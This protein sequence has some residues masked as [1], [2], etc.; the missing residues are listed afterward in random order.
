MRT[1]PEAG[2]M[3]PWGH[4]AFGYLLYSVLVRVR[5]RRPPGDA[6]TV[7]LAVGTQF[8]DLVDK[9]LA[10]SLDV[11]PS[12]RSLAHSAFTA[13]FVVFVVWAVLR[14]RNAETAAAAFGV[15]Y[16]SHLVGDALDPVLAGDY[17]HLGFLGWPLVPAIEY[18][19]EQ[20]FVAHFRELSL[21][22]LTSVEAG[23]AV[24]ITLL[25]LVDGAPGARAL[26]TIPK[27]ARRVLSA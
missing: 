22:S 17:Y 14:R 13:A 21:G 23:F 5:T 20:S 9:P 27:W 25:W 19:T 11:L 4:L 16:V 2:G 24:A 1:E 12:G 8:P 7:A 10:W 15:G 26:R 6:A 18:P 3:W